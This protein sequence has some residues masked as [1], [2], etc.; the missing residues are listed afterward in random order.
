MNLTFPEKRMLVLLLAS[1]LDALVG[2]PK[3]LW[4]PVQGIGALISFLEKGLWKIFRLSDA[5]E[6]DRGKKRLAGSVLCV[7]VPVCTVLIVIL[8]LYL[9]SLISPILSF[10][11][12]VLFSCQCLAA[13]SLRDASMAVYRPLV[14]GDLPAARKAVSMVVG[15]DTGVLDRTGVTKA[16]VETV[17]E[18]ASDG[19]IAPLF[20]L[21]LLGPA[22]GFF[23]KAVNT[24]DSM[25]GYKNDRYR[26]FGSA[27]AHLDDVVNFIP[28]RLSG[29]L[30]VAAS[31]ILR[32]DGRN[33]WRIFLRDR[34]KHLSPNAGQ[35]ESAAAGALDVQLGGDAQYFGHMVQKA[36]LGDPLREVTP[37]DIRTMNRLMIVTA[38]L[39][40]FLF[41]LV[42]FLLTI[43]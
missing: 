30:M 10:V 7:L 6:E 15:R 26:Y 19:V 35:T 13:R 21:F 24:M 33:A 4:H 18:N 36:A 11:L 1:C 40:L 41:E 31:F 17:A 42:L 27:A 14:S 22:G 23:Y 8:L 5:R 12:E 16:A 38:V 20:Y 9:A 3:W 28:A 2:D 34:G 37:E 39:S 32:L 25:I 43:L 29:L